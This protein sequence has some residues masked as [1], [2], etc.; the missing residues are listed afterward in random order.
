LIIPDSIIAQYNLLDLVLNGYILVEII[1]CMCGLPHAGNLAYEQLITHLTKYI[2]DLC[3]HTLGLWKHDSRNVT[4]CLVVDDF[5]AK[6]VDE[7]DAKHFLYALHELYEFTTDWMEPLYT[8][9]TLDCDYLEGTIDVSM[10]CFIGKALQRFKNH[11]SNRPQRP[12]PLPHART[13]PKYG[14]HPQLTALHDESPPTKI[15]EITDT[16]IF[17]CHIINPT[18]LVSLGTISSTQTK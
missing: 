10:P 18:M 7:D 14:H 11:L 15:E 5:G 9:L 17:Y 4:F 13:H 16:L 6:Y 2:H 1:K 8:G 3:P 12:Q